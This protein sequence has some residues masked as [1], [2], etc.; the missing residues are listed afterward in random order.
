MNLSLL[1]GPLAHAI[2]WTLLHLVWQGALV[3]V[4]LAVLLHLCGRSANLRYLLS[5]G[6]LTVIVALGVVTAIRSYPVGVLAPVVTSRP[7]SV[8]PALDGVAPGFALLATATAVTTTGVAPDRFRSYVRAANDALPVIVTLWILGVVLLS[9]RLGLDWLKARRLVDQSRTSICDEWQASL[10]RLA[11]ALGVR[12]AVRLLESAAIEVPTVIGV[13]RPAILLPASTLVGLT[14]VQLEM[15]LAHELAHIRRHD[16]L[17]NLLQTAVE[18]LLF[19]HPAV[20]WISRQ[21]RIERENCCDDLAVAV[22]GSPLHYARALA[23]LEELRVTPPALAVSA[24]GGSLFQR[25]RRLVASSTGSS[26][27]AVRGLSAAA[28]LSC[29]LLML[30]AQSFSAIGARRTAHERAPHV[31]V[32][33]DKNVSVASE[34]EMAHDAI[35]GTPN[36]KP[37]RDAVAGEPDPAVVSDAA[38]DAAAD[39]AADAAPEAA[40]AAVGSSDSG[41]TEEPGAADGR[42]TLEDLIAL[43][44]QNVTADMVRELRQ[45][46]PGVRLQQIAGFYA[47]G[48]TP[49][50]VRDMRAFG[51][52]I[53]CAEEAQNLAA[54]GVTREYV[55]QMRKM[56][57]ALTSP[58]DASSMCAVGVTPEYVRQMRA[59]GFPVDKP[60]DAQGLCAVGVTPEYVREMKRA[61]VEMTQG[62]AQ[63]L[64]AVGVTP[65]FVRK[66]AAAGYPNATASQLSRLAAAGVTGDFIREMA[67]YRSK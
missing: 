66:L 62:D 21:V 65:E 16:F 29:L 17:V 48:A 51:L 4:V 61:G 34:K 9:I 54:V 41:D 30:A 35:Q 3:A 5:C 40:V 47:V 63:S 67:Q 25:V 53:T 33:Q 43:R 26:A 60:G 52:D 12:H 58:G 36:G 39:A 15:I 28:I 2:G 31:K 32:A 50:Y 57:F 46:F 18:T 38:I 20:W 23:R 24:T 59:A 42:P 45:L 14:P 10:R 13:I 27:P 1:S 7:E 19:Y 37:S 56:G 55:R 49:E 6:A 11:A 64:C 44:S 8:T 22:C